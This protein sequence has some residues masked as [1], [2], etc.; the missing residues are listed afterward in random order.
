MIN[1]A[2]FND[3]LVENLEFDEDKVLITLNPTNNESKCPCCE[4]IWQV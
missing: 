4:C 1:E 3:F 2:F